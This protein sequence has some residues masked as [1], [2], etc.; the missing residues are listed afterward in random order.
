MKH[1]T[2]ASIFGFEHEAVKQTNKQKSQAIRNL[3]A[4]F[5]V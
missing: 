1:L 3:H 5:K 4:N 2:Y